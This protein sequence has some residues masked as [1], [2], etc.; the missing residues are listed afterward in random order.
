MGKVKPVRVQPVR[1]QR[2]RKHKMVSPNGLPIVYVGRPSKWGSP[3]FVNPART[4][5]K[6]NPPEIIGDIFACKNAREA[7]QQYK[8]TCIGSKLRLHFQVEN[9]IKELK[10]KNLCCWC[11]LEDKDGNKVPCHADI[12]LRLANNV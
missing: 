11:P 12:L 1:V 9:I 7:V 5:E 4:L 2:S 8:R 3:F 6:H 10:G